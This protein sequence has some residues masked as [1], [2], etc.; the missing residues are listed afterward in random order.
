MAK[1]NKNIVHETETDEQ[2]QARWKKNEKTAR[3]FA[4]QAGLLKTAIKERKE[5][6]NQKK[7]A[8]RS[9]RTNY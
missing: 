6:E 9:G 3:S 7:A 4:K 2:K 8:N 1:K 5:T